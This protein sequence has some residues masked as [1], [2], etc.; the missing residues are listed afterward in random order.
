MKR[1]VLAVAL[2]VSMYAV[3][4]G[5]AKDSKEAQRPPQ[6]VNWEGQVIRATGAGAPDMKASS[7]A[8]ARLGA[9]RAALLDAFR[10]LLSQVKGVQVDGTRKMDDVMQSNEVRARVEGLIK[11]YKVVNKRYFSDNGVEID[12]EVPVAMLTDILDPD[13]TQMLAVPATKTEPVKA[14]EKPAEKPAEKGT[15]PVLAKSEEGTGTGLVIDARGLKLMPALMPRVLDEA[16]KPLYTVDSLSA[17]A[18]KTTGVAAYVQSLDEA[19]KSMKAGDKPMVVKAAKA[20]GTDVLL[21]HEE[22]KKLVS[23]NP[24]FLA[25]GKVVIVFN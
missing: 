15:E 12:V 20:N 18:R 22:A 7:P 13:A 4:Q 8:Q 3:A 19:R 10:N 16:G 11:G 25:Q 2:A 24:P 5:A 1:L 17:E 9:E 6:G 23:M 21:P 14:A